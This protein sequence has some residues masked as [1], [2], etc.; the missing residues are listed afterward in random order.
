MQ[1]ER[2]GGGIVNVTCPN[3]INKVWDNWNSYG[4]DKDNERNK[5]YHY[6]NYQQ[7]VSIK[8]TKN[9]TILNRGE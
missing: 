3:M 9:M 8:L 1:D 4:K 6:Q 7:N 2:G 5:H